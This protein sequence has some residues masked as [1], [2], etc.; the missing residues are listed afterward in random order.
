MPSRT[1]PPAPITLR[2]P[3]EDREALALLS[4]GTTNSAVLR[5]GLGLLSRLQTAA[6]PPLYALSVDSPA[7]QEALGAAARAAAEAL[8]PLF[9]GK[10]KET[11]G[12]SSNFYGLLVEHMRAMLLGKEGA[13]RAYR[14]TLP[15]LL[16]DE[17]VF[18]TV[19][20]AERDEGFCLAKVP[21]TRGE[22]LTFFDSER[23]SFVS[24]ER[25]EVGSLF[26]SAREATKAGLAWLHVEEQSPRDVHLR[27]CVLGWDGSERGIFLRAL[28]A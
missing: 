27:L 25:V 4:R 21:P 13:L 12:I 26:T 7:V 18:G 23:N 2:L 28:A 22:P 3:D 1:P 6:Q 11:A 14:T 15:C 8:D 20:E 16:A 5:Q 17:D 19:R 9:T 10:P 24:L